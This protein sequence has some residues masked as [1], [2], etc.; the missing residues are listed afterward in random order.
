M[1][2]PHESFL[3]EPGSVLYVPE[4]YW[5]ETDSEED[6]CSLHAHVTPYHWIDALLSTVRSRLI[7]DE[8]FRATAYPLWSPD[9]RGATRAH[10]QELIKEVA[11]SL[12]SLTVED[13]LPRAPNESVP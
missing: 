3:L 6:A 4:G 8:R 11:S 12:T 10:T 1:P 9:D 5:H 7:A 13:V 2:E